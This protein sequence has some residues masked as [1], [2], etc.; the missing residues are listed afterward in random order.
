M[1][2]SIHELKTHL[3]WKK[4]LFGKICKNI[5]DRI[6]NPKEAKTN[7]Y[8]GLEHLDSEQPKIHRYGTPDDVN[9]TKL[10]FKPG[11]ISS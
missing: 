8:V 9:A 11:Q 7:Y 10:R 2:V 1:T 6:E 4:I 3:I 5:S